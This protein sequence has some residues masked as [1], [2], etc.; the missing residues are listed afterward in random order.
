MKNFKS[1]YEML[2]VEQ[3]EAFEHMKSGENIFLTGDAGTGKSY[4]VD[5]F[6]LYCAQEH[7][8]IMK[9]APTGIASKNIEGST[10]HRQFKIDIGVQIKP[11]KKYI[12]AL[13]Y[14]DIVLIDE[15]SMCRLDLFDYIM[16][17]IDMCNEYRKSIGSREIQ[18]ILVGDFSQLPP[19]IKPDERGILKS[20]YK[21]DIKSGYCF[22]SAYWKSLSIHMIRLSQVIRQEDKQFCEALTKA[23]E[24]NR[25]CIHYIMDNS[26]K[27]EIKDAVWLVGKNKTVAE[28]NEKKLS[29][30][31]GRMYECVAEKE[32]EVKQ[33]DYACDDVF[34]FKVGAKVIMLI[35]D[36]ENEYY[37]NGSVGKIV[38]VENNLDG[39]SEDLIKLYKA[40]GITVE[41]KVNAV[42]VE[43][44]NGRKKNR[45]RVERHKFSNFVYEIKE[46]KKRI[47][48][49]KNRKE[50]DKNCKGTGKERNWKRNTVPDAFR[51]CD[52]ST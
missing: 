35:N 43:F 23:K 47:I 3:K 28:L 24:G 19:V 46:K 41:N 13:D 22:Q 42:T 12:K 44:K 37:Q 51:L 15:I 16:K 11:P 20:Y 25:E 48:D 27:N 30:L 39:M 14:T 7:I 21:K 10:L 34:S 5:V 52:Y 31:R 29:E 36:N 2:N 32:G 38:A 49:E 8:S 1:A 45:V 26:C 40:L 17:Q 33:S 9:C 18:I 4:L 6:N 50:K